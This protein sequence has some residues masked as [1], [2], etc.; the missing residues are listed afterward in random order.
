MDIKKWIMSLIPKDDEDSIPDVAGLGMSLRSF[1]WL[2]IL[3]IFTF[4]VFLYCLRG[5]YW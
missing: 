1:K 2:L 3:V 5:C 4:G